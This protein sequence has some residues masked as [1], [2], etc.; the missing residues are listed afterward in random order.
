MHF[1]GAYPGCTV[2]DCSTT[3]RE[4]SGD[5]SGRSAGWRA[6]GRGSAELAACG[7]SSHWGKFAITTTLCIQ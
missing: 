4:G 3:C 6:A 1:M 5:H 2:G 7:H